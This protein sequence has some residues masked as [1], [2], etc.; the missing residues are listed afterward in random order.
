M[1][2]PLSTSSAQITQS[3]TTTTI[4]NYTAV[5]A[6]TEYSI[7]LPS[8]TKTFVLR[9]RGLGQIILAFNSGETATKFITIP[10][11]SSY[12]DEN[13]YT[14]QTIYFQTTVAGDTIELLT[15]V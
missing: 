15:S 2:I 12:K 8:S 14:S 1:A 10:G 7:A 9:S 6:N 4:T 5:S 11:G 13:F 3:N